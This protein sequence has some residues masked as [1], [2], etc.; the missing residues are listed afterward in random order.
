MTSDNLREDRE[1]MRTK[2]SLEHFQH[3]MP[4]A[5][6]SFYADG[7]NLSS[8]L[9]ITSVT[10]SGGRADDSKAAPGGQIPRNILR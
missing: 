3:H 6:C 8:V 4:A 5:R 9:P 7:I 2:L 1:D 10:L